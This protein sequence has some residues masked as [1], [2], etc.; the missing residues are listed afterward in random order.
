V[1]WY[2]TL[3]IQQV[4]RP[5]AEA[6]E[7]AYPGI[8]VR[9][10]RQTSSDLAVRITTEAQAGKVL[11]DVFDGASTIFPLLDAGLVGQYSPAA[12]EEYPAEYR[13]PQ[14]FWFAMN[15]YFMTPAYNTA[16]VPAAEVPGT[17]PDLLHERWRGRIAW[18]A[19][20]TPAGPPGFIAAV[21]GTMGQEKGMAFLRQ[22]ASQKPVNVPAAQRTVLDQVIAGEYPLALMTF[23]HHSAISGEQGAPVKWIPMEP[24]IGTM[25]LVGLMKD[26]PHPNA[27]RLF[28]DFVASEEGQRVIAAANYIPAHPRVA[29]RVPDLKPEKGGFKVF[30]ITPDMVRQQLPDWARIYKELFQ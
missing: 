3:I 15:T 18:A 14:G 12:V 17:W 13:D 27:A 28:L 25:N 5:V 22:L 10:I 2:S 21:L 8:R 26:A 23:N 29:A 1:V 9:Y 19:D 24:V 7:K 20:P 4:I 11:T 16:N 30:V 6:F